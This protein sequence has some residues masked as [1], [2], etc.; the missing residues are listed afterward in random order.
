[1]SLKSNHLER[2]Y[3]M[4]QKGYYTAGSSFSNIS[5]PFWGILC[6]LPNLSREQI[7]RVK[8]VLVGASKLKRYEKM[9]HASNKFTFLP[10]NFTR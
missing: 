8:L 1:M 4:E 2:N 10:T 9:D 7:K 3:L 5:C 6:Y